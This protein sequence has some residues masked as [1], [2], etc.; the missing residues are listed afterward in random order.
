MRSILIYLDTHVVVWLYAGLTT[1]FSQRVQE[2]INGSEIYISPIVRLEL[3]YLY[4]INRITDQP[5]TIVTDLANRIGLQVAQ[6]SFDTIVS[7]ALAISWT[8]DP[9]DRIIAAQAG[10]NSHILVTKDRTFLK[11]YPSAVW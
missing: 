11:N 4:E 9:F 10:L 1:L 2:L 6:E 5:D 7:Q 8:R 3:Q